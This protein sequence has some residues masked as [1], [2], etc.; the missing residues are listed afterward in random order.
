[1][2]RV[3]DTEDP[4]H[5][6]DP[7]MLEHARRL[8][9]SYDDERP[10]TEILSAVGLFHWLRFTARG[11]EDP[12]EAAIAFWAFARC[13]IYDDEPPPRKLI[14]HVLPEAVNLATGLLQRAAE[15]DDLHLTEQAVDAWQRIET[16]TPADH[17]DQ[18][19]M[20]ANLRVALLLRFGQTEDPADLEEAIPVWEQALEALPADHPDRADL[21]SQLGCAL[22][23]RFE[24]A[25]TPQD[26]EKA[27]AAWRQAVQITPAGRPDRAVHLFNLSTGLRIRADLTGTPADREEAATVEEQAARARRENDLQ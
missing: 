6:L 25:E 24:R 23:T 18:A 15:S 22:L 9:A 26:L 13:M 12:E 20:W 1:M 14:P 27:I 7:V 21:L 4:S 19:V 2:D 16:A 17:P 11:G 3:V 8:V 10:D 5:V